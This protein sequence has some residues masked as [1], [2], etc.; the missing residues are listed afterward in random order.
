M[1]TKTNAR[2]EILAFVAAKGWELD[3]TATINWRGGWGSASKTVQ[4][5]FAFRKVAADGGTWQ[6]KL[7]FKVKDD[8]YWSSG[9]RTD[10]RLRG[11]ELRKF[12]A[13]GTEVNLPLRDRLLHGTPVALR[14]INSDVARYVSTSWLWEVTGE[15]G[16]SIRKR[17]EK[18][19]A[20]PDLVVWLANEAEWNYDEANRRAWALRRQEQELRDRPLPEGWSTLSKAA[21]AIV[22]ADG[23][24][25]PVALI[26][27]LRDGIAAV[28]L[29]IIKDEETV[30]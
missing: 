5:P 20:D 12:A 19:F 14:L 28:T 7:D 24:S 16:T 21:Q 15:A 11:I 18:L 1:T 13:D 9:N 27:A 22:N 23:K 25:D 8:G 10:N 17:A 6:A 3:T 30:H 4:D 2:T 26:A 29:S